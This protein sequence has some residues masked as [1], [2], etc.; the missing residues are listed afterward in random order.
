VRETEAEAE[1]GYVVVKQ[2]AN[3]SAVVFLVFGGAKSR[4][5]FF[6]GAVALR[7][8]LTDTSSSYA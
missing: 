6:I 3:L 5:R 2:A 1:A 4:L 8:L 7:P